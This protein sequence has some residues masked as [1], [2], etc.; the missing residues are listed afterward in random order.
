MYIP[1]RINFFEDSLLDDYKK[2]SIM[3]TDIIERK[4][5]YELQMEVPGIK[6]E[7]INVDLDGNILN[8]AINV[9]NSISEDEKYVKRERFNGE[10][11]RSFSLG[12]ISL[13]EDD[14]RASLDNGILYLNIPK[15][16]DK[17]TKKVIKIN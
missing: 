10:I 16:N 13:E 14:I 11:K 8:I 5:E 3:N 6:K 15:K 17:E 12:D 1:S 4:D 9:S 2:P 7:D